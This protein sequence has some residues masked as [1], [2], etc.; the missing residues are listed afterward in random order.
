MSTQHQAGS[1]PK[2]RSQKILGRL[3]AGVKPTS[4]GDLQRSTSDGR[5]VRAVRTGV[6]PLYGSNIS[7]SSV[8]SA[9]SNMSLPRNGQVSSATTGSA[10]SSNAGTP[11]RQMSI[12]STTSDS[13]QR[14]SRRVGSG[15]G[16]SVQ[17]RRG[18]AST[19]GRRGSQ[20]NEVS[21]SAMQSSSRSR[22]KGKR[23]PG[24]AAVAQG[25]GGR[26]GS[27][28]GKSSVKRASSKSSRVASGREPA[29]LVPA[30]LAPVPP[31]PPKRR[32]KKSLDKGDIEA[33][34]GN[35]TDTSVLED[36]PDKTVMEMVQAYLK[37]QDLQTRIAL[38]GLLV[39]L[40]GGV[41]GA[42]GVIFYRAVIE[43]NTKFIVLLICFTVIIVWVVWKVSLKYV[44]FRDFRISSLALER[45]FFYLVVHVWVCKAPSF[46]LLYPFSIMFCPF[47]TLRDRSGVSRVVNL[48]DL[49]VPAVSRLPPLLPNNDCGL[50]FKTF[51][52]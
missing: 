1:T 23:G 51:S 25:S 17:Q 40:G 4:P 33:G 52:L 13:R 38:I 10:T 47:H 27:E 21:T 3:A 34:D 32:T 24:K 31:P 28:T 50:Y 35:T 26:E 44:P 39:V 6:N 18:K 19:S 22:Q 36:A 20:K 14:S 7:V 49:K 11:A 48:I 5:L 41:F 12:T 15:G 46:T 8:Q 45:C 37:K 43:G 42:Y 2:A 29:P 30:L 16:S 9:P